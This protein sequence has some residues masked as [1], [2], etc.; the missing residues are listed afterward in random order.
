MIPFRWWGLI[1]WGYEGEATQSIGKESV[2]ERQ[3]VGKELIPC[4][5]T[6]GV[7]KHRVHGHHI[8]GYCIVAIVPM[9]ILSAAIVSVAVTPIVILSMAIPSLNI[10][11]VTIK[12]GNSR[13]V[14]YGGKWGMGKTMVSGR[15]TLW[16]TLRFV[17][18]AR[19]GSWKK[20]CPD[21]SSAAVWHNG[22][23]FSLCGWYRRQLQKAVETTQTFFIEA[24]NGFF[25]NTAEVYTNRALL[26][27]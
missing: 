9:T 4:Q 24:T 15:L 13:V 18:W 22:W 6:R 16:S 23:V 2:D 20:Y 1:Q 5:M 8:H 26:R 17:Y 10:E 12:F 19:R 11:S 21:K 25:V 27:P 14:L 3:G 7:G